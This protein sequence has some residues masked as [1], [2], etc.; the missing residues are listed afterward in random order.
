VASVL[1]PTPEERQSMDKAAES[2]GSADVL[3]PLTSCGK[4][5]LTLRLIAESVGSAGYPTPKIDVGMA[6]LSGA[7]AI[8]V[9]PAVQMNAPVHDVAVTGSGDGKVRVSAVMHPPSAELWTPFA[10][11]ETD[12]T[13]PGPVVLRTAVVKG[14]FPGTT[15][16]LEYECG[17]IKLMTD[18]NRSTAFTSAELSHPAS[19]WKLVSVTRD[20]SVFTG[21]TATGTVEFV[22]GP[23]DAG[24]VGRFQTLYTFLAGFFDQW[25]K[26]ERDAARLAAA[27]EKNGIG[28]EGIDR[29]QVKPAEDERKDAD[30][31]DDEDWDT[32]DSSAQSVMPSREEMMA[33]FAQKAPLRFIGE[34]QDTC[35]SVPQVNLGIQLA[36][37][38]DGKSKAAT[39]LL[40]EFSSGTGYEQALAAVGGYM[41]KQPLP[42]DPTLRG[43]I[44][45]YAMITNVY[46][47]AVR[48]LD[49]EGKDA[50]ENILG[51]TFVDVSSVPYK[52]GWGALP[53]IEPA[54]LWAGS[55]EAHAAFWNVLKGRIPAAAEDFAA[56][57]CHESLREPARAV[58]RALILGTI[59]P[60]RS[61]MNQAFSAAPKAV[62][63]FFIRSLP[64]IVIE[65]RGSS[66][67]TL[68][69][70]ISGGRLENP[71]AADAL[72][73][74]FAAIA[75]GDGAVLSS[76]P[77]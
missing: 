18:K 48:K 24:D 70:R 60:Q 32:S 53:K 40:G 12:V 23:M 2:G 51:G 37:L 5:T 25:K 13:A 69:L 3:S 65:L 52:N 22:T 67:N 58:F 14:N 56:A 71:G 28:V 50:V 27:M 36:A 57:F 6:I 21:S 39:L 54:A 49:Y 64:A 61:T 77:Q 68:P 7:P 10:A 11:V 17:E 63:P 19:N 59:S 8:D 4:W 34:N 29:S 47:D 44:V 76:L 46:A 30:S 41:G 73:K 31:D 66:K 1:P 72:M 55:A 38:G 35:S 26:G 33:I 45:L 20:I 74:T 9:P 62:D 16:G 43:I 42:P 75:L 15:V